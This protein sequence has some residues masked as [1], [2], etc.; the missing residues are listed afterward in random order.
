MS[1]IFFNSRIFNLS[2]AKF[3]EVYTKREHLQRFFYAVERN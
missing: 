2:K 3:M 1:E